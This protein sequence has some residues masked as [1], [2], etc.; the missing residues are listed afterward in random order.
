MEY[1]FRNGFRNLLRKLNALFERLETRSPVVNVIAVDNFQNGDDK[2]TAGTVGTA[3]GISDRK[4]K[5]KTGSNGRDPDSARH[6][7]YCD[8]G[9]RKLRAAAAAEEDQHDGAENYFTV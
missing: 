8:H 5:M 1:E 3:A 2:Y 6:H 9:T 7:C 4:M